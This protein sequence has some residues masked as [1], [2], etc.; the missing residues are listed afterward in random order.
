MMNYD[1]ISQLYVYLPQ[2]QWKNLAMLNKTTYSDYNLLNLPKLITTKKEFLEACKTDHIEDVHYS[3]KNNNE[4]V[5][6]ENSIL[7]SRLGNLDLIRLFVR[8]GR[9]RRLSKYSYIFLH[10]AC[11]DGHI[12]IVK[13]ILL[14]YRTNLDHSLIVA[15]QEKHWD[16]CEL[17]IENGARR[18]KHNHD[19][20]QCNP[21]EC[22]LL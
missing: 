16:I 9:Y 18:V 6:F 21:G 3:I 15:C 11:L 17:L 1:I 4:F 10:H 14:H 8:Y 13:Y 5:D 20:C 2:R 12:R 7:I 22:V 19:H